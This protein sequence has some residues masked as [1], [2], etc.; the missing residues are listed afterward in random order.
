MAATAPTGT[1]AT[2]EYRQDTVASRGLRAGG[3]RQPS[4]PGVGGPAGVRSAREVSRARFRTMA[5]MRAQTELQGRHLGGRPPTV[6]CWPMPVRIP[7]EYMPRG[8]GVCTGWSLIRA[9]RRMSGGCSPSGLLVVVSPASL[10]NSTTTACRAHRVLTGTVTRT[11]KVTV[12]CPRPSLPSWRTP[13][14]PVVR[15]GTGSPRPA[16]ASILS[17]ASRGRVRCSVGGCQTVG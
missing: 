12:G 3:L 8:G 15:C 17:M 5:A 2:K 14:T 7:I 11:A 1:V 10:V 4:P 16:M 9:R 13:D 6:T